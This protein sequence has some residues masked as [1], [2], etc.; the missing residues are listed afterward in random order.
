MCDRDWA[1]VPATVNQGGA[2]LPFYTRDSISVFT[3]PSC[4]V[5]TWLG[6]LIGVT[7]SSLDWKPSKF[8][9]DTGSMDS[10][11]RTPPM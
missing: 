9:A 3:H 1:L 10:L 5:G 11:R 7:S 6:S 2:R 4:E 8:P